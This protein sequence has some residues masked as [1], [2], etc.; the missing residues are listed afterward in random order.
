M[1]K[2]IRVFMDWFYRPLLQRY[3]RKDRTYTYD[4]LELV[5][6]QGV[7]HPAFFGSTFAFLEFLKQQS[8]KG[9]KI[10]EIGCGS[11]LLSLEAARMG[12]RVVAVDI[13]PE[14]V[15]CTRDNARR[16]GL[17]VEAIESDLFTALPAEQFDCLIVNPPYFEGVPEE[18][19]SHAWYSGEGHQFFHRF[20]EQLP[21]YVKPKGK[22]WMVLSEVCEL[23]RIHR[24]AE[25]GRCMMKECYRSQRVF[26]QFMIYEIEHEA[27]KEAEKDGR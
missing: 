6:L 17:Q 2:I 1:R 16:N 25:Q 14:A 21:Q 22:S 5:I 8:L 19:A 3:L 4:N 9:K 23:A 15:R 20:F 7:F 13:N 11:G 10:L 27:A 12:A 24:I 18:E 26:E